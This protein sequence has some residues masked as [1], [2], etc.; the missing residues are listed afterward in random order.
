MTGD[1]PSMAFEVPQTPDAR[2]WNLAPGDA[3]QRLESWLEAGRDQIPLWLP[4]GLG[5]GIAAWFS[6]PDPPAWM[7]WISFCLGL[8][9]ASL[10][11]PAGL[12]LGR[13]LLAA[14]L[15]GACG[16]LLVWGKSALVAEPVLERPLFARFSARVEQA[17]PLPAR[18][19]VRVALTPVGRPDL[20]PRVRIN[21]A[22]KDVPAG[23]AK[24][25]VISLRAR[26]MP[27][28][29]PAVPGAYDFSQ[30]AWFEG[31]GA[32]G[33]A[34]PPVAL[35]VPA[36]GGADPPLRQRLSAHIQA[37]LEGGAGAIAAT[38]ATGDR[39]AIS[40]EDAEA[41]RRSGLAHLLSIS[42][43]HVSALVGG[44]VLL[45][46]RLLALSTRLALRWPLLLIAAGAGA[47]AGIGYTLLTGAEVPTIRSC[48]AALLV[49]GG[50]ALGREAITLRLVAAGAVF[51][52]L[53]WPEALV[54]PSFQLSFAA[55]VAI[56][57]LH[58]HSGFRGIVERREDDH[59]AF[60]LLRPLLA[61]FLTGVAV[62]IA[63]S[64]IALYHFHKAGLLGAFANIIAIP[65]TTF[66][67][68]P[69][70]VLAL[71]LDVAGLGAPAWWLVGKTLGLLLW[72][73]HFVAGQPGAVALLPTFPDWAFALTIAGGLWISLWRTGARWW[74][75]IPLMAGLAG[76]LSAPAPDLLV[77]GDGRHM[78]VR[79]REG[80]LALL[81]G[82]A[83]DYVRNMLAE[84][85]GH[86]GE[87]DEIAQLPH[88]RCS[89][90]LCAVTLMSD[91][92]EWRVLATRS[93]YLVPW[94]QLAAHCRAS[95]IVVS[96][97]RL[98]GS[99]RPRWL[100]LDRPYLRRHG[101]ISVIL[102]TRRVQTAIDPG[103]RHP[104][105]RGVGG[106]E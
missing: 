13:I 101:G 79:T 87:L 46:F 9:A 96:D 97:R 40:E 55:V 18:A 49:L 50:M 54:G 28:A 69:L 29:G 71:L 70:E 52:L 11:L 67:V 77:T 75:G 12:R 24:G 1:A 95:D 72:V 106:V 63:L 44:V 94:R 56:V 90:D 42:G 81:R 88:A 92:R 31:I 89:P 91:G 80:G 17:E 32:T 61:L 2:G 15:L 98:P 57:A 84:N 48:V 82:R 5:L 104:W 74:G 93:G 34:V 58:E 62:E 100:K 8:A 53:F 60:R 45:V 3:L 85:A 83:G 41:M 99:C 6:L 19:M 76:M 64:P 78:V 4:V 68:M 36:P 7:A 35:I 30:R 43:L 103:D 37:R 39:G 22:E 20:P 59:F 51:V 66:V 26:L 25:S 105:V 33:R 38:L 16:C 10:L 102:E 47:A 65:L 86:E 14:G 73:A 23:L 21:I 27:P